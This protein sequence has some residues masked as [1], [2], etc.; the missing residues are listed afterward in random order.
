[1]TESDGASPSSLASDQNV[2][3][4]KIQTVSTRIRVS[5]ETS[6]RFSTLTEDNKRQIDEYLKSSTLADALRMN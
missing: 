4:F 1:M 2:S 3:D 6:E 5:T